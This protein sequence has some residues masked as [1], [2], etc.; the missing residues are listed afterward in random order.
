MLE[1][2]PSLEKLLSDAID[3]KLSEVHTSFPAKV[4]RVDVT[5]AQCDVQPLL[6]RKYPDGTVVALPQITNVPICVYR[7]GQAFISLPVKVG[8]LVKIDV[9]ERSLDLW[10]LSGALTD[11]K[12][13][14]RF[15]LSDA[16]AYPGVYPFS[17]PPVGASAT[18]VVIKNGSGTMELTPNGKFKM[19]GALYEMFT[20]LVALAD[21]LIAAKTTD[22]VSGANPFD[23]PTLAALNT[24][25]TQITSLKA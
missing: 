22:P 7:A 3:R 13:P 4:T 2:T 11:P 14:R 18:N 21:T 23:A 17:N 5:I 16:M 20:V 24:F 1:L 25:K 8:D 6:K 10:L 12:D 19:Q 15:N 9:S